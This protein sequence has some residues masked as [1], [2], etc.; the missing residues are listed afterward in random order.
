MGK[1]PG[2]TIAGATP[3]AATLT[4]MDDITL[5]TKGTYQLHI[6]YIGQFLDKLIHHGFTLNLQKCRFLQLSIQ[7]LGHT[8]GW[9]GVSPTP[10]YVA[11]VAGFQNF[12]K[13]KD[14]QAW[15]GLI[16]FYRGYLRHYVQRIAAMRRC[17][18]VCR[19]DRS[20]TDLRDAWTAECDASRCRAR[21]EA[22]SRTR[23]SAGRFVSSAIVA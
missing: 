11:K 2:I 3:D 10:T 13:A 4:Y 12:T 16:G 19:L 1:A 20:R 22:H 14:A 8:V 6:Q 7:L 15:L 18:E 17:L 9:L 21:N 23:T 5:V